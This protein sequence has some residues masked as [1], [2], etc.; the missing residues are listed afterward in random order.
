MLTFWK[1]Y[2]ASALLDDYVFIH[3]LYFLGWGIITESDLNLID[4]ILPTIYFS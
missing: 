1:I 4:K 3:T 2:K